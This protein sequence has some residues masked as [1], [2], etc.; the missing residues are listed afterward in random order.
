LFDIIILRFTAHEI[1]S[2]QLPKVQNN[3]DKNASRTCL[4]LKKETVPKSLMKPIPSA[5]IGD[6][7]AKHFTKDY[8]QFLQY[9]RVFITHVALTFFFIKTIEQHQKYTETVQDCGKSLFLTAKQAL[10]FTDSRKFF[11][12]FLLFHRK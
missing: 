3:V 8:I 1:R 5:E 2:S 11:F 6:T 9:V 4:T 12:F 7:H 10:H